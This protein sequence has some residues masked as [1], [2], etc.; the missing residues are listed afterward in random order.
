MDVLAVR[1]AAETALEWVRAGKGPIILEMKTYRY[2]G[3]SM[4]D[5]AKYRSARRCTRCARSR[6]PIEHVEEAARGDGAS[7]ADLKAIDNEVKKIVVDAADFAAAGAEPDPAELYTDVY[8]WRAMMPIDPDARALSDHGGGHARQMAGQGRRQGRS[9]ATSS[10]RSRPTRR[11]WNSRPSTRARSPDPGAEGTDGVKVNTPSPSGGEG[12]DASAAAASQRP[13]RRPMPRRGRWEGRAAERPEDRAARRRHP[14][15]DGD[16]GARPGRRRGG[17]RRS[18][19][20]RGHR[21]GPDDRARGAARRHGRGDAPRRA[22]LRDGRGGRRISGRLQGHPG[23][24][25]EFGERAGDRHADHRIWLRRHR[26]R[27]GDGRPEADRRVHDLQ[28]RHAG[29]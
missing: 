15:P 23:P 21:D 6:D 2:R 8:W 3:H 4:S 10:P 22:R 20:A 19:N 16:R 24:A 18:G 13:R 27:R 7:E 14:A 9:P 25:D 5:P 12:E 29:D 28:L 1:G 26:H 11:R 17:P